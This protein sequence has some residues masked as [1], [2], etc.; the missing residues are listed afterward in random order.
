[1]L[2]GET[3]PTP[4]SGTVPAS[5]GLAASQTILATQGQHL[6]LMNCAHCHGDDAR[7]DEGP[8]LHNVH[9]GDARI[10]QIVIGGIKGEMPSFGKKLNENDV[11]ALIAY[12]RTLKT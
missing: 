5:S 7:G 1:M 6:F 11:Q 8:D 10:H 3:A 9:K 4:S 12:L 2:L